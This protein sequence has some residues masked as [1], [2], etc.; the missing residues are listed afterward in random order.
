MKAVWE[1]NGWDDVRP[2]WVHHSWHRKA[3]VREDE[4]H[5][6]VHL[7]EGML[8]KL[9][10]PLNLSQWSSGHLDLTF[11]WWVE[12]LTWRAVGRIESKQPG[13]WWGRARSKSWSWSRLLRA[14]EAIRKETIPSWVITTL[15]E[16]IQKQKR[17]PKNSRLW[18][19]LCSNLWTERWF[20]VLL[21][22]SLLCYDWD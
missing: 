14:Q 7:M 15:D 5:E 17:W 1:S 10:H 4:I 16:S 22:I 6:G 12:D 9:N 13:Y 18:L 8:G 2:G 11:R 20:G 3:V 19:S 21:W